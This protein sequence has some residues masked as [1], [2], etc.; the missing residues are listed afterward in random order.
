[1]STKLRNLI[2]VEEGQGMTEYGLVLGT[3]A[4]GVV[5]IL[6]ALKTQVDEFYKKVTGDIIQVS[7]QKK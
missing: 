3:I 1:M 7:I 2:F 6:S 4:I 5:V